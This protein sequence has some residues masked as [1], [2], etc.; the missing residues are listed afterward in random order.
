MQKYI[1]GRVVQVIICIWGITLIVFILG[2]LSGDPAL[3]YAPPDATAQDIKKIR[4]DL[5]LN[6]SV[7]TQYW[8]FLSKAVQGDLGY[9]FKWRE[10]SI[11]LVLSRIPATIQLASAALLITLI[12]ALPIGI[13]SAV[14]RGSILDTFGRIFA[15][16]GQSM[17]TFWAG[18]MLMLVFSVT[19][20]ILPTS[21]RGGLKHLVLPALA[22]GWYPS[23]AIMRLTRSGMLDVLDS[24]YIKMA[25]AKGIPHT[26]VVFK[27]ALKN[28]S[29]PVV[30][31]LGLQVAQLFSGAVIIETIFGWPGMGRLVI[32]AIST[33][34]YPVVQA[35]VLLTSITL[36]VTNL[37]VDILYV[38]LDPRIK[39]D[40]AK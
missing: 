33:G 38:Y 11:S 8:V 13:L 17:P 4:T 36:I 21:G 30:T 35:G 12:I 32:Q 28:A 5:G 27:H 31:L 19:F 14:K 1:L 2:R 18:I 26:V 23:A 16:L 10:S 34:D 39:Y 20:R 15:L 25:K 40:Q 9:S 3:L 6:K 24:E 7:I 29:I 22:L 37:L